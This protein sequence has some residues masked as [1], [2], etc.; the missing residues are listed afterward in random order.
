MTI[1]VALSRQSTI[2]CSR[3]IN[4]QT[5]SLAQFV[6]ALLPEQVLMKLS[7]RLIY[8]LHHHKFHACA[9]D[10]QSK[11]HETLGHKWEYNN[12]AI[13]AWER[14]SWG[15]DTHLTCFESSEKPTTFVSV[16]NDL[17]LPASSKL[18]PLAACRS[19][20]TVN[21]G[22]LWSWACLPKSNWTWTLTLS[23][24]SELTLNI[25]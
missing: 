3:K 4:T 20:A 2:D 9:N 8:F 12:T 19:W 6:V 25:N 14:V 1:H 16:A 5:E 11:E 18:L 7:G 10:F 21:S 17:L 24:Q 23:G 13:V 15:E 22:E